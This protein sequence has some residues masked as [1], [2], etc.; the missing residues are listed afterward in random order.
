[1]KP[2]TEKDLGKHLNSIVMIRAGH[3]RMGIRM[4]T[5]GIRIRCNKQELMLTGQQ[6]DM[7]LK[8]TKDLQQQLEVANKL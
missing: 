4:F 8:G 6:V 2:T 1:M 7:L 5:N 3:G